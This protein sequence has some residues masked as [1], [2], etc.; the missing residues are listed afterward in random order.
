MHQ[1]QVINELLSNGDKSMDNIY[2]S[3]EPSVAQSSKKKK[4]RRNNKTPAVEVE[5]KSSDH[6]ETPDRVQESEVVGKIS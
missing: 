4:K 2:E 1:D 3:D 6:G 5:A